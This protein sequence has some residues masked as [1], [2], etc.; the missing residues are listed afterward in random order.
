MNF[1]DEARRVDDEKGRSPSSAQ[2]IFIFLGEINH[3]HLKC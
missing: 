1:F 2:R 3:E